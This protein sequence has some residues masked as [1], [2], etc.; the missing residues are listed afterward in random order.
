VLKQVTSKSARIS[1]QPNHLPTP[2]N[3]PLATAIAL[4]LSLSI[5]T[6]QAAVIN[7]DSISDTDTGVCRLRDAIIAANTDAVFEGCAAGSGAD[8]IRLFKPLGNT[9]SLTGSR[10]PTVTT[11]ITIQGDGVSVNGGGAVGLLAASGVSANLSI[12]HLSLINGS[13]VDGG[14]V[15]IDD[16]AKVKLSNST[17][18]GNT[19][20]T[21][22]GAIHVSEA[23]LTLL[24]STLSGNSATTNGGGIYSYEPYSP[25]IL[26]TLSLTNSTLSGNT[27]GT[28]GGGVSVNAGSVG[29][30]GTRDGSKVNLVNSTL[31]GNQA[32]GY[33]GGF[34]A[35]NGADLRLNNSVIA[36]S[37]GSADDYHC[38]TDQA[39]LNF[40]T[41][42]I[43]GNTDYCIVGI[44]INDTDPDLGPLAING[45]PS[46]THKPNPGSPLI[47]ASVKDCA[48]NIDDTNLPEEFPDLL[49]DQRGFQRTDGNCDIGAVEVNGAPRQTGPDFV[50]N[51]AQDPHIQIFN[52]DPAKVVPGG[53]GFCNEAPGD[54]TLREAVSSANE[55]SDLSTISFDNN[56]ISAGAITLQGTQLPMVVSNLTVQGAGMAINGTDTVTVPPPCDPCNAITLFR[57][58]E[59]DSSSLIINDL[60]LRQGFAD[61]GGAI[62][63][64][65]GSTLELN[66]STLT[67]SVANRGAGLSAEPGSQVILNNSTI[68]SNRA[69]DIGGGIYAG[70]GATVTI[71]HSNL[72]GNFTNDSSA[73]CQITESIPYID[74]Q[75][76]G[77]GMFLVSAM[78]TLNNSTL[79]HNVAG[80]GGV[81]GGIS[82]HGGILAIN[83]S[84]LSGNQG[85][86]LYSKQ[87]NFN[88]SNSTLSGNSEPTSGGGV[89]ALSNSEG[90]ITNST[91]VDNVAGQGGGLFINDS[92]VTLTNST[93]ANSIVGGD[94]SSVGGSLTITG[95]NLIKDG[96]GGCGLTPGPDLLTGDPMLGPL[97]DNGG[98]TRT[99]FPLTDSPVIDVGD[100]GSVPEDLLDDQR[101]IGFPR[102][103]NIN[104]DLGSVEWNDL[105]FANG[106]EGNEP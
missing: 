19:A 59:V 73:S 43:E 100:N 20:S 103:V 47:N 30:D 23:E 58:F 75:C 61:S 8:T 27:A 14:A 37:E 33:G 13:A 56:V 101:G 10:L 94:C 79:D 62:L 34:H 96:G 82:S 38:Y 57:F 42:L 80:D 55:S 3:R 105:I 78:V 26:S 84:T 97:A 53:D 51:S 45:G 71:N 6:A 5:A 1:L 93:M 40:G 99:H 17:V 60:S 104:V 15:L 91:F 39:G 72:D 11:D 95:V 64:G 41:N 25:Y 76:G 65:G 22:G 35:V 7:V 81:G 21:N 49:S 87:T 44:V 12:D 28:H 50:V 32:A 92:T 77:A 16:S 24:N 102:F 89:W 18:S 68:R 88:I 70:T 85:S 52:T 67:N 4:A 63:V 9:I 66:D 54:C 48:I 90:Q 31:T 106:L 98:P 2:R 74:V 86:A 29:F 46:Q 36:N 83:N 69:D